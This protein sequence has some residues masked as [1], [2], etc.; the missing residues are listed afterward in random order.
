MQTSSQKRQHALRNP[1]ISGYVRHIPKH[2]VLAASALSA[3]LLVFAMLPSDRAVATRQNDNRNIQN[4]A[5]PLINSY[6]E[7]ASD[8]KEGHA[9]EGHPPASHLETQQTSAPGQRPATSQGRVL[10]S[11]TEVVKSGD[12]LSIIFKRAGIDQ[13]TIAELINSSEEGKQLSVLQPGHLFEFRIDSSGQLQSLKYVK[14]RLQ[15]LAFIRNDTGFTY[16]EFTRKPDTFL[17]TRS[18]T[19]NNS[20]FLAGKQ[21]KLDDNVV[22]SLAGIFGWDIDFALDIRAGDSFKLL[23]EE[24]F[25]D[26]EKV[27]NGNILA[28]EFTNRGTRYRAVRYEDEQGNAQYYTPTGETMRKEFLRTPIDFAR[29]SSHFN[30]RRKHPVLNRIRAHKGTDYAA[31]RGTPIKAAGDGKVIY[32][33]RKGGY[34]NVVIIQHGQTY[35]TLYAH[36]SKFRKGI[37]TGKR[38]KQGQ[39]IAYVGSTGLATGPHLHYEFYVNGAVRNPVTVKLPKAKAIAKEKLPRFL[40]QT[41][42]LLAELAP[43]R[44]GGSQYATLETDTNDTK[45]L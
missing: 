6:E 2:H 10:T 30:L 33:G 29:I 20:L 36:I 43:D 15:Q 8:A 9:E 40:A 3:L 14:S 16:S 19:I 28:A 13:G 24:S 35:K 12:S 34:G 21:A 18:A 22:M 7:E 41:K 23:Y 25:L 45:S 37:R 38:V 17:S 32:A 5:I 26:G 31:G 1:R 39:V 42:P 4:V 27:G 11:H 44:D